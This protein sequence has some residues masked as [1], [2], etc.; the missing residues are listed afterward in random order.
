MSL[1]MEIDEEETDRVEAAMARL[2]SLG[3][4]VQRSSVVVV[5]DTLPIGTDAS[6]LR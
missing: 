1:V 3:S 4:S 5:G 6:F 2:R